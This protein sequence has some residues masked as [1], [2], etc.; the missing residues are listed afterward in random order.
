MKYKLLYGMTLSVFVVVG[1]VPAL[2]N[3]V[4]DGPY[5]G[6]KGGRDTYHM[7]YT[8]TYDDG[9]DTGSATVDNIGGT[10]FQGGIFAGYDLEVSGSHLAVEGEYDFGSA[11][12][13]FSVT[14]NGLTLATTVEARHTFGFS[15]RYGYEV[16][17][18]AM[19]YVRGGWV[20]TNFKS[21][22]GSSD[23]LD[24]WRF[25]GGIELGLSR[26]VSLRA[27]YLYTDYDNLTYVD[28]GISTETLSVAGDQFNL[29]LAVRF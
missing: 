5:I 10:G 11:D 9:I 3:G 24:G 14:A 8:A 16:L 27:E 26:R 29:G 25:G 12:T 23:N 6:V 13:V 21:S 2:A 20:R 17:P 4:L 15:A 7:K 19:L 28:P 1:A 22:D 18:R